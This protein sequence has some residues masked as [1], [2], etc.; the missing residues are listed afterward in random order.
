MGWW[1]WLIEGLWYWI[2]IQIV[3]GYNQDMKNGIGIYM[4]RP[5]DQSP[6]NVPFFQSGQWLFT[7][8][9]RLNFKD[10]TKA[11]ACW[12]IGVN[13]VGEVHCKVCNLFSLFP[14]WFCVVCLQWQCDPQCDS[15]TAVRSIKTTPSLHCCL[16]CFRQQEAVVVLFNLLF[17][18][19]GFPFYPL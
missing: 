1:E 17:C 19:S 14:V 7:L 12:L 5:R 9:L 8:L 13:A 16:R 15:V 3:S 4:E 2:V 6:S 10:C 18:S 11:T